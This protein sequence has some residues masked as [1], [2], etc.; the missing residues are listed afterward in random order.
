MARASV[1]SLRS[2]PL[3]AW[4]THQNRDPVAPLPGPFLLVGG[5]C[6]IRLRKKAPRQK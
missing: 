1:P 4:Q 2:L 5:T 3:P 6:L